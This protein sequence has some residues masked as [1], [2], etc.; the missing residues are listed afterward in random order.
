VERKSLFT[1]HF[2]NFLCGEKLK[3]WPSPLFSAKTNHTCYQKPNLSRE[4]VPLRVKEK[5]TILISAASTK[6]K[7]FPI[8]YE[9]KNIFSKPIATGTC[10]LKPLILYT[11]SAV[12]VVVSEW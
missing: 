10:S 1:D 3:K 5:I 8:N 9:K 6:K 2:Q 4:T 11:K 7:E 12:I